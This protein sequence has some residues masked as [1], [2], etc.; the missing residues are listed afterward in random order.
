[1]NYVQKNLWSMIHGKQLVKLGEHQISVIM[2]N[3]LCAL[4]FLHSANIMHRDIKPSN[5]LIDNKCRIKLCDFGMSRTIVLK[6]VQQDTY[7]DQMIQKPLDKIETNFIKIKR[8]LT[9]HICTRWYRAPEVII[10]EDYY[11]SKIDIW[12]L[13]CVLGELLLYQKRIEKSNQNK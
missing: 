1:M 3:M 2:Y 5:I 10:K 9:M 13:G 7:F 8:D 4:Q 12:S 11:D 6:K